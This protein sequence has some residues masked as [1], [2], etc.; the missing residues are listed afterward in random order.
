MYI[1][2]V[3]TVTTYARAQ[4]YL[5]STRRRAWKQGETVGLS[6]TV[7]DNTTDEPLSSARWVPIA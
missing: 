4:R 2:T 7:R 5:L 3:E 1:L 6:F